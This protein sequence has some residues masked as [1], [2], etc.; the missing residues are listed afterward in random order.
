[1]VELEHTKFSENG[2]PD[3][4]VDQPGGNLKPLGEEL[5]SALAISEADKRE[6]AVSPRYGA[7]VQGKGLWQRAPGLGGMERPRGSLAELGVAVV[8]IVEAFELGQLPLQ[9]GQGGKLLG[10]EKEL[11]IDIVEFLDDAVTP[12]FA[13]GNEND[14]HTEIQA[15]AD[16]EAETAGIEIGSPK[17]ELIVQLEI[18]RDP[19][20]LPGCHEGIH[21]L[22]VA[23]A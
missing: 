22:D 9:V 21:D 3:V 23:L 17:R 5:D 1:M 13:L 7:T 16:K 18:T 8:P 11:V 2:S 20:S 6:L 15:E 4:L 10:A 12:G 14:F 19:Q